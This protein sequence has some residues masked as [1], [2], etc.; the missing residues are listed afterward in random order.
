MMIGLYYVRA[1]VDVGVINE[2]EGDRE[3]GNAR[4]SWLP[5]GK[6]DSCARGRSASPLGSVIVIVTVTD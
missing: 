5:D 1:E 2:R 6:Y 4:N 3:R